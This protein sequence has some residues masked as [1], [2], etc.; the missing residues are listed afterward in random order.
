MIT[1]IYIYGIHNWRIL[2]SSY[3]KLAWV[4]FEPTTTEFR[5]DALTEWAISP[6]VQLALRANFVQLFQFHRLLSVTFHFGYY[7]FFIYVFICI[8]K[9]YFSNKAVE[10]V[11]LPSILC[12]T[13]LVSLLKDFS[14]K[15]ARP[16]ALYNLNHLWIF[17]YSI[18]QICIQYKYWSVFGR[19]F[20]VL[21]VT[22]E[23][24]LLRILVMATLSQVILVNKQRKN[25]T[26]WLKFW[27]PG[28]THFH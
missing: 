10:L 5:L 27:E 8:S 9:A 26:K 17:L 22:T 11:N 16:T 7:L 28:K 23:L 14:Y 13:H 2:W 6:W 12:N 25:L 3:R 15:F 21:Y 1:Y 20:L 24:L 18:L 4:G 19:S